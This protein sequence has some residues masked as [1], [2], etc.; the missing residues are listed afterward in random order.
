MT[1]Q[2]GLGG[3]TSVFYLEGKQFKSLN[4]DAFCP[5]VFCGVFQTVQTDIRS[6]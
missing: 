1:K 3:K 5:G 6:A 4:Q 2:V